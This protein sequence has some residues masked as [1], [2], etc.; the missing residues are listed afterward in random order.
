MSVIAGVMSGCQRSTAISIR[1]AAT[2]GQATARKIFFPAPIAV[3]P[4][5]VPP[6]LT[7]GNVY[8]ANGYRQ[9]RL[10]LND[11]AREVSAALMT[12]LKDA[13]LK[14]STIG[15]M[16][17]GSELPVGIDF[18]LVPAI[19]ELRCV[20]RIESSDADGRPRFTMSAAATIK[21]SL[22][23][24]GGPLYSAAKFGSVEEPPRGADPA[25][26]NPP[27]TRPEDAISAAVSQA[28]SKLIADPSFQQVLPRQTAASGVVH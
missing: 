5:I 20:K 21:F 14:P 4:A 17:P 19:E 13:G 22:V 12:A 9:T 3:A 7:L 28:I 27:F 18:G 1:Y 26:Y 11:P 6:N 2:N 15:G 10:G 25:R 16:P 24:R 8:D 23:G